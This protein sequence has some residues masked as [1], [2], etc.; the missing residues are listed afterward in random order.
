M[1][2]PLNAPPLQVSYARVASGP[3]DTRTMSVPQ[4]QRVS[5]GGAAAGGYGQTGYDYQQQQVRLAVGWLLGWVPVRAGT[6]WPWA[7]GGKE[8]G[9]SSRPSEDLMHQCICQ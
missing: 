3:H 8:Q 7:G 6:G 2:T 5:A 1:T 9:G 4:T